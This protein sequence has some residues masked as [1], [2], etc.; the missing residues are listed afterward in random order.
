[1]NGPEAISSG[2]FCAEE[3]AVDCPAATAC[4]INDLPDRSAGAP[5]MIES[6]DRLLIF[7]I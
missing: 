5:A 7:M 6:A 1:L 3:G 2:T 4:A